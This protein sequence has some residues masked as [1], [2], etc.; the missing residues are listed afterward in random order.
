MWVSKTM[1]NFMLII[2]QL[3]KKPKMAN[4]KFTDRK[5]W[6]AKT[7]PLLLLSSKSFRQIP[8]S[9]LIFLNLRVKCCAAN[10]QYITEEALFKVFFKST[11]NFAFFYKQ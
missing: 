8:F 9:G 2:K 4:K 5:V 6:E 3:S 11:Q 1:K 10:L 7:G